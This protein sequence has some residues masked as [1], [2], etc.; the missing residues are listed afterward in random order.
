MISTDI[1]FSFYLSFFIKRNTTSYNSLLL[2]WQARFGI[3]ADGIAKNENQ[4]YD[5]KATLINAIKSTEEINEDTC[6]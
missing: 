3:I 6:N 1:V 2:Y 5:K 4:E